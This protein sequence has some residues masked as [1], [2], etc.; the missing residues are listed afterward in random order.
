MKHVHCTLDINTFQIR[1]LCKLYSEA[2][3]VL[4][5]CEPL[6]DVLCGALPSQG[7]TTFEGKRMR[8]KI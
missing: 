7:L 4:S 3:C 1:H 6:I 5:T 2:K 8:A